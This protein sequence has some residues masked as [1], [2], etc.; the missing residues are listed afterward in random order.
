MRIV[1]FMAYAIA[2]YKETS[3]KDN[4]LLDCLWAM[5]TDM[6]FKS[7]DA[8]TLP[9]WHELQQVQQVQKP[10][11]SKSAMKENIRRYIKARGK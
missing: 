7:G 10:E 2:K 5:S 4:Y 11:I 6:R 9:R 8:P 1:P 3:K